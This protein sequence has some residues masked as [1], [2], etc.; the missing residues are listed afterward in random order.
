MYGKPIL[1]SLRDLPLDEARQVLDVLLNKMDAEHKTDVEDAVIFV[2]E[3]GNMLGSMGGQPRKVYALELGD[4]IGDGPA[5]F[6]PEDDNF[7]F[8]Q[9][10]FK[11]SNLVIVIPPEFEE[12]KFIMLDEIELTE[13]QT[14]IIDILSMAGFDKVVVVL[15]YQ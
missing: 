11:G 14:D 10:S 12:E 2:M 9:S 15:P 6:M 7:H 13:A 8:D 3:D 5:I 1:E 4:A